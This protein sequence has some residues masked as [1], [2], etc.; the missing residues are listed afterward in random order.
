MEGCFMFQWGGGGG[1]VFFRWGDSFLSWGGV[2]H[3]GGIGLGA[4]GFKK[5]IRW[6]GGHPLHAPH[7]LWETL[8]LLA[9]DSSDIV[10]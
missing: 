8:T 4:G 3:G 9:I 6:G 7:L 1:R 10:S 2:P 5:I